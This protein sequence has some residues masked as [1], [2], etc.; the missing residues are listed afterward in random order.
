MDVS[1]MLLASQGWSGFL[2]LFFFNYLL[3]WLVERK[4]MLPALFG[5]YH[6]NV[7]GNKLNVLRKRVWLATEYSMESK[8][9]GY[10]M[11]KWFFGKLEGDRYSACVFAR[12]SFIDALK[13]DDDIPE[14]IDSN[15]MPPFI[16]A[17]SREGAYNSLSYTASIYKPPRYP[18]SDDQ[19]RVVN[20]LY[21]EF[22]RERLG[23]KKEYATA[24][25]TGVPGSGKSS[26][27][28]LL[29][30]KLLEEERKYP[31]I[32]D[33]Y[34]PCDPNDLFV[35]MYG[36]IC[37]SEERPLI[38]LLDEADGIISRMKKPELFNSKQFPYQIKDKSSWNSFFDSFGK[39]KFRHVYLILTTN[40]PLEWFD[41]E[42]ESYLRGGRIDLRLEMNHKV[43]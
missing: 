40:K 4:T 15:T 24:I 22:N 35:S 30:Q 16:S 11:G 26:I 41:G 20:V 6:I 1:T 14:K 2:T 42:D 19:K 27:P 18:A 21:E 3:P 36:N 37:P 5:F 28:I 34:H 39:N 8:A 13:K 43:I 12:K 7:Y 29:A 31:Y 17:I 38:I 32:V 9:S 23:A 10:I 25:I 33:T